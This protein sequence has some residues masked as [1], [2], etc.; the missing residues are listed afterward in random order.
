MHPFYMMS[1][2]EMTRK[3]LHTLIALKQSRC[4]PLELV[5]PLLFIAQIIQFSL[6]REVA[7]Y[8]EI[9]SSDYEVHTLG[10]TLLDSPVPEDGNVLSPEA[11]SI[12]SP[13]EDSDGS[14]DQENAVYDKM[15]E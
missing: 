8:F 10:E 5:T 1:Y 13:G 12:S 2:K 11:E 15:T 7:E 14:S 4:P 3:P 6:Q 9:N